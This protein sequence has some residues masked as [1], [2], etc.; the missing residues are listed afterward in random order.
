[1]RQLGGEVVLMFL[2]CLAFDEIDCAAH[3]VEGFAEV[4]G[5][6]GYLLGA[7]LDGGW[8]DEGGEVLLAVGRQR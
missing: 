3:D 1:M 2:L 7:E 5:L 4:A 6:G 8:V